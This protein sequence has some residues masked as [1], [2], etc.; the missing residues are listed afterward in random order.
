M[1]KLDSEADSAANQI[2]LII[3]SRRYNIMSQENLVDR[4]C[5]DAAAA[6]LK[7]FSPSSS[8][9]NDEDESQEELLS[10]DDV[11]RSNGEIENGDDDRN[12][13]RRRRGN[14]VSNDVI[15]ATLPG[16][17]IDGRE[18][19]EEGKEDQYARLLERLRR[20]DEHTP[21]H[22]TVCC[23]L[24]RYVRPFPHCLWRF[25]Q[26]ELPQK[27]LGVINCEY[28]YTPGSINTD[29]YHF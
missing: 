21:L 3:F 14:G 24:C 29:E 11:H 6:E 20:F 17:V 27:S 5:G 13:R 10:N 25:H 18:M 1:A 12:E 15:G 16:D 26:K 19:K 2:S 23:S 22:K 28:L 4:N 9:E 7:L 8:L